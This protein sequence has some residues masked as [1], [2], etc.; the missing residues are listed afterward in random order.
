MKFPSELELLHYLAPATFVFCYLS[1]FLICYK[2]LLSLPFLEILVYNG[3]FKNGEL[4]LEHSTQP[5][6]I[7]FSVERSHWN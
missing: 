2:H 6:Q 3:S 1:L 5:K 7:K 4:Y